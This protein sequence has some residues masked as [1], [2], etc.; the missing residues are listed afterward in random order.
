MIRL[1]LIGQA[2][3]D[4]TGMAAKLAIPTHTKAARKIAEESLVLLKNSKDM[5]PL[6][7]AQYKNVAVIGANATEVFAAGG[8]STKLKAK[9]EVTPLEGLQNLLDGKARIEYAPGYQLNK[10]HIRLAIGSRTNLIN[11]MKSYIRKQS[12]QLLKQNW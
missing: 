4:T 3:Y 1:D 7:P 12:I 2:P 11:S 9:Y 6:D 10:R 8:G 5:L